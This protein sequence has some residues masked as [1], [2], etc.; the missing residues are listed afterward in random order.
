[1]F[2]LLVLFATLVL[3]VSSAPTKLTPDFFSENLDYSKTY[4][5][6]FKI[7]D[8]IEK[9]NIKKFRALQE[10]KQQE[11]GS[12][13]GPAV[14]NNESEATHPTIEVTTETSSE[15]SLPEIDLT[16]EA[17]NNDEV[18]GN[19]DSLDTYRP[20]VEEVTTL[21]SL[22]EES[23]VITTLSSVTEEAVTEDS[24][25]EEAA[26]TVS[27]TTT[28]SP[29]AASSAAPTGAPT[30]QPESP[31]TITYEN[32]DDGENEILNEIDTGDDKFFISKESVESA[33]KYGYKILL[34]KIG[35][36]EVPVGK[37]KFSFPTLVE[38]DHVEDEESKQETE[39][40]T[41]EGN[42]PVGEEGVTSSVNENEQSINEENA[43][44]GE[45]NVTSSV[46][47]NALNSETTIPTY[48][49][50]TEVETTTALSVTFLPP[51]LESVIPTIE[52][53]D[54]NTITEGVKQITEDTEVAINEIKNQNPSET[55]VFEEC[56]APFTDVE[57]MLTSLA[58]IIENQTP[59]ISEI[60]AV[61]K[62]LKDV[63]SPEILS[64][65]GARLLKLLEPFLES[66]VPTDLS[67]CVGESS[68]AMVISLSG[69][70]SQLDTIASNHIN[71]DRANALHKSATSLQLAAWIMAQLQSSVHTIY[72][73]EGICGDGESST[74]KI[75]GSLSKAI[76]GY[77]PIVA[78]MGT[79]ESVDELRDTI[80]ALN[81][82][83]ADIENL[84][85]VSGT[86]LPG[87]ECGASFSEMGEA[88]E[89]LADFVEALDNNH[90]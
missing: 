87:V 43:P 56:A 82:A 31:T 49:V 72:S 34:K 11:I 20:K 19:V 63:S 1:M 78:M 30:A 52:E 59:M 41:N 48:E 24:K 8:L 17:I 53:L 85:A 33:K 42:T 74:A 61:G 64:R 88:L 86:N 80:D 46:N 38:I 15:S 69:T 60:L 66:L 57:N 77:L 65:S 23:S 89:N 2:C 45:E 39:Q 25:E 9:I 26:S 51:P 14:I 27:V 21:S 84:T 10:S 67:G 54:E 5:Q 79:Q 28:S 71:Q 3:N 62:S 81:K 13:T 44:V 35:G 6:F 55:I 36:K 47:E 50:K 40:S 90:V 68:N 18:N 32:V 73:Q 83:Q 58:K 22:G 7:K 12:Q 75:L 29:A 70:A 76:T 4:L 16:V 37:I